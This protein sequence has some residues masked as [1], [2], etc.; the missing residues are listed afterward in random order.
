MFADGT[1]A[2]HGWCGGL[3]PVLSAVFWARGR[4]L[5]GERKQVEARQPTDLDVECVFVV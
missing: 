4:V 1:V 3:F 2:G 5:G